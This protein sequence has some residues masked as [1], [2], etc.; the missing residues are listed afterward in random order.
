M[1]SSRGY[2]TATM[3]EIA[4]VYFDLGDVLVNNRTA[5][6]R[7]A[8]HTGKPLPDVELF[9]ET[10]AI[11]ACRGEFSERDYFALLRRELGGTHSATH[12][13]EYW[14]GMVDPVPEAHDLAI[15][16][17]KTHSLGILSNTE[18]GAFEWG[19]AK[20]KI[21]DIDWKSVVTSAKIGVVKPEKEIFEIAQEKAGVPHGHILL[22]D[23]RRDNIVAAQALGWQ[24]LQFDP[25]NPKKSATQVERLLS[26]P[27]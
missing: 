18:E 17:S 10:Y 15:K 12:F 3:K 9:F 16:L 4:F 14:M 23:D 25:S 27:A 11:R 1:A 2:K 21:P 22:I 13:S 24:G 7:I 5:H 26:V 6:E 8:T 20:G 19:K